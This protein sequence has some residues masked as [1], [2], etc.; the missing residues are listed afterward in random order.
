MTTKRIYLAGPDVFYPD[1][2]ERAMA[3][4]QYCQALGYEPLHP[5]D[6]ELNTAQAIYQSNID[7]LR[8][9]DAVIAN[10]NPFR[11]AEPDSGT[12]FEMGFA[13][14]LGLPVVGYVSADRDTVSQV[15]R[16]LGKGAVCYDTE[17]E[18]WLDDQGCFI[19]GFGLHANLM[20]AV[21]SEIV[22]GE[23]QDAMFTMHQHLSRAR[24][25]SPKVTA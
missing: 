8:E 10:L 21:S 22:V 12:S 19:E 4:K 5:S 17:R 16:A 13:I 2:A 23:F 15:M 25:L 1:A 6:N 18:L 7:M 24:P 3:H 11:G 14:A 20:I 9:A